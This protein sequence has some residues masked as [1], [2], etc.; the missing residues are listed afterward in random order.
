MQEDN[1]EIEDVMHFDEKNNILKDIDLIKL[2][3]YLNYIISK[4][5]QNEEQFK[6]FT[7]ESRKI[8]LINPSKPQLLHYYRKLIC[9]NVFLK[10][11]EFEKLITR[12]LARVLSGVLVITV[13][14]SPKPKYKDNN[15]NVKVQTFSCGKNCAYCPKETEIILNCIVENVYYKDPFYVIDIKSFDPI[16]DICVITYIILGNERLYCRNYDSFDI[17]KKTFKVYMKTKFGEKLNKNDDIKCVKVEQARSYISTEDGVRRANQS[18]YDCVLQFFDRASTYEKMGFDIDKIE[19]LVLGG[20]FSHYPL[21]YQYEFIKDI[22]YSANIYYSKIQREKGTLKEEQKINE[23]SECRIIG[24]TLETRPDCI[25]LREIKK[26]LE[27]MVTR[28]QL[29]VQHIDDYLLKVIDRGCYNIDTINAIKLAKDCCL[30]VDIHLMPD[31]PESTR[32]KDKLMFDK[33]LG[34]NSI[35]RYH[36]F[37]IIDVILIILIIT[38]TIFIDIKLLFFIIFL[39][40]NNN[41]VV[42]DLKYPELQADQWK[43]YPTEVTRWTKIKEWYDTGKYVPYSEEIDNNGRKKI[44][45]LILHIKEN[46]FPWI[47]FNRVIRD[48]PESE[49]YGGNSCMNLRQQLHDILKSEGKYCKCIRCREVKNK[50]VDIN[51]IKLIIRKYNSSEGFEYFIS[52]ES[53]DEKILYGF[54]RLRIIENKYNKLKELEKCALIRELHV[55]GFMTSHRSNLKSTQHSGFGTKL[56]KK[57]EQFAYLNGFK[58]IAVI[59]GMGVREYY[60]KKGYYQNDVFMIKTLNIK[61]IFI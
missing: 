46:V 5:P 40:K 47:R 50:K 1:L 24:L 45:N 59:S 38:S 33:L 54:C 31:L 26:F 16:D 34:V 29:G 35:K 14:T 8:Y 43:I 58:K 3:N 57:A 25:N 56:L 6:K 49:I 42:Y 12:K 9:D 7:N 37:Q 17:I 41:F 2:K 10:D 27:F 36:S 20:T 11:K 60:K 44:I 18:N 19:L 21:A 30:K 39:K 48:F 28:I 15:D 22:Y 52:Y 23:T 51:D 53:K 4:K 61:N 13:F 32:E 55:Y